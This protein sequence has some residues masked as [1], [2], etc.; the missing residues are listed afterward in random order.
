MIA[1]FFSVFAESRISFGLPQLTALLL[2]DGNMLDEERHEDGEINAKE[3]SC[4]QESCTKH[5]SNRSVF[6]FHHSVV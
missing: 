6:T 2:S 4:H 3:D 5:T 1:T